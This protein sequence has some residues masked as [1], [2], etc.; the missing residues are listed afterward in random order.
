[1]VSWFFHSLKSILSHS[2]SILFTGGSAISIDGCL[3]KRSGAGRVGK[4]RH[5]MLDMSTSVHQNQEFGDLAV[6]GTEALELEKLGFS[7]EQL[8]LVGAQGPRA[9]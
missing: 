7:Q 5:D 2:E 4:D 6:S 3:G 1:M 8:Q 9:V